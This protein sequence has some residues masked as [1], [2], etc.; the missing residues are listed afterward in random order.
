MR[1]N[2]TIIC[3]LSVAR[4]PKNSPLAELHSSISVGFMV[5][6]L[7]GEIVNSTSTFISSDVT[8]FLKGLLNGRNLHTERIEDILREV[9]FA[10]HG[11]SQKAV[12][13]CLKSDYDKYIAWREEHGFDCSFAHRK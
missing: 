13:A 11:T 7:T 9:E 3:F 12:C 4:L 6:Y 8:E 2:N 1:K 10:Y 5:D